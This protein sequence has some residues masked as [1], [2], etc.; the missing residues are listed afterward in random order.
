M[1]SLL[2]TVPP[3]GYGGA[4]QREVVVAVLTGGQS[5]R[6]GVP[7]SSVIV[8]GRSMVEWVLGAAVA[9]G[10][11]AFEVGEN[12]EHRGRHLGP[13]AGIEAALHRA[14]GSAVVAVAVDQPWVRPETLRHLA[15]LPGAAVVPRHNDRLQVTCALYT[16]ACLEPAGALLDTGPHPVAALIERVAASIVDHAVWSAWGED[17]R[18][19]FS[20]DTQADL[21]A[22]I[23]R[24]G[25]PGSLG[26]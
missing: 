17:G 14:N 26:P 7:K 16:P 20:A 11:D 18:S 12:L 9:A 6:M 22:G 10:L 25:P 3:G 5:T 2:E 23:G 1:G 24:F 4:V 13:L 8:A 21:D 19:W 15:A